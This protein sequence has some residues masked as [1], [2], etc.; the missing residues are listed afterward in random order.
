MATTFAYA[1]HARHTKYITCTIECGE[2]FLAHEDAR[3]FEN[4]GLRF[5][6]IENLGSA[7]T[8]RLYTHNVNLGG[9]YFQ[10]LTAL[11]I[12]DVA[13]KQLLVLPIFA[14]GLLYIFLASRL[15]SGDPLLAI[16]V[17]LLFCT[18]YIP[19]LGVRQ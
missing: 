12:R 14:L 2:T 8:P 1:Q 18:A 5:A 3:Q 16:I 11:G 15:V 6:L 4:V 9:I 10:L 19:V 13:T 7:D 17:L